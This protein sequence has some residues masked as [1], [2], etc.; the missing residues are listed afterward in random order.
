MGSRLGT[1]E[2]MLHWG[3]YMGDLNYSFYKKS[4]ECRAHCIFS[5]QTTLNILHNKREMTGQGNN[6]TERKVLFFI[7]GINNQFLPISML[8]IYIIGCNGLY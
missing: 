7:F 6:F 2:T 4:M 1:W 5:A 3:S 8:G